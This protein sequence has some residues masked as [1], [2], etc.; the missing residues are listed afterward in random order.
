MATNTMVFDQVYK[1][2]ESYRETLRL[3]YDHANSGH[4]T[5]DRTVHFRL[6]EAG[7]AVKCE[8]DDEDAVGVTVSWDNNN[9]GL[10]CLSREVMNNL[11]S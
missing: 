11:C 2:L 10:R 1:V 4:G 8:E 5:F 7:K 9:A 6:N 3:E